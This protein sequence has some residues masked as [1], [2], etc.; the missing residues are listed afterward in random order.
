MNSSRRNSQRRP[1][2]RSRQRSS[3]RR[4][5]R[6]RKSRT[7]HRRASV[8]REHK[9]DFPAVSRSR[10]DNYSRE[11]REGA[12]ERRSSRYHRHNRGHSDGSVRRA[13]RTEP[14]E[15]RPRSNERRNEEK[16]NSANPFRTGANPFAQ[17][18]FPTDP[19]GKLS[20]ALSSIACNAESGAQ[21]V[22]STRIIL[23]KLWH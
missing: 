12:Y 4:R 8:G 7:P 2:S 22:F 10:Y 18:Q 20:R 17:F 11:R 21:G 13:P 9:D 1:R 14:V 16:D 6:S 5:N 23:I 19:R 15:G 3:S